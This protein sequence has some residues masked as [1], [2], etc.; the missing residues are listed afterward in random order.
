MSN[1]SGFERGVFAGILVAVGA[2]A[3]NWFITPMSHP[4]A[5]TLRNVG[6]AI[7]AVL[8]LGVGIWLIMRERIRSTKTAAGAV[9]AS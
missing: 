4:D 9:N 5:S 7:Q 2:S 8:G 6:V 3:V 1:S